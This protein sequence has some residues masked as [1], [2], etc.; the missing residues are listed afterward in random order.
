MAFTT[1]SRSSA[2]P[3]EALSWQTDVETQG[4]STIARP[5]A[6]VRVRGQARPA[7]PEDPVEC[8][9]TG[10][11]LFELDGSADDPDKN[12][13]SFAWFRDSRTGPQVGTRSSVELEQP[14]GTT[15]YVFSS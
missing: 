12:I 5:A 11:A 9:D 8:N 1:E 3:I 13:A 15:S 6:I 4:P 10:R 14:L 7:R 2:R